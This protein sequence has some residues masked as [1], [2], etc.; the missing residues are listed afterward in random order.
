MHKTLR[1]ILGD[2]LNHAHSWFQKKDDSVLYL[3]IEQRSETDYIRHHVQKVAAIFSAMRQF[4]A[5][6]R[7][8]GFSF[9]YYKLDDTRNL[10]TFSENIIDVIKKMQLIHFEYQQPDE[11]R[12]DEELATLCS[13]LIETHNVSHQ[14]Y[15]TEH[16]LTTRDEVSNLF[17][18]KKSF[19]ME[20]F[21]QY[22]RRKYQILMEKDMRTPLTGQWNYDHDNRKKLPKDIVVP[23]PKTF[24]KDVSEIITMLKLQNVDTIGEIANNN[25]TWATN[26]DEALALLEHFIG[27]Q[28]ANFGAYEDAMST[29]HRV[30]FH[31]QLSF[32]LNVKL[33]HPLEVV[34]TVER[35]YLKR[36]DSISIASVEGFVRQII[37]WREY[38]RGVYWYNMPN[39]PQMNYFNHQRALPDYF[40]T[41][42][43]GMNCLQQALQ[44]SL[45][46]AYAHHIQ[47]LMI[48]GNFSLL[49][50]ADPQAVDDW[51]LGVYADAIEWV[52]MPNTRAMSQY[53]DGGQ[54]ATKPYT[55][56]ANYVQKMSNY[57]ESCKYNPKLKHG[58]K[59]CPLNSLYWNFYEQH[60]ELLSKNVR[61]AITY[62]QLDKMDKDEKAKILAQ[63]ALYLNQVE[64][65]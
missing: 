2:Q 46:H 3:M 56:S 13:D 17:A 19:L 58:E 26:R 53:A 5:E 62:S 40:W 52:Q 29:E 4:C 39:Y 15:S 33:L 20:T 25:L 38:V 63:A 44:N 60:R 36:Q 43:T 10:P 12:L 57:C 18:G 27:E 32:C 21:Y 37:G 31:S 42:K 64:Q 11:Y 50:A 49:I 45:Q 16:F 65:L 28:L 41:G 24:D 47:R 59:A 23:A 6:K 61:L 22:M 51:Y 7:A 30:A 8:Q 1:L 14:S 54:M 35:Y 34:K 55:A 9:L 48:I